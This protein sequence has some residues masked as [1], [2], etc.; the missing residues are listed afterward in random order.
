MCAFIDNQNLYNSINYFK[1]FFNWKAQLLEYEVMNL[2][3][4]CE[5]LNAWQASSRII[6]MLSEKGY[7]E[8]VY[9]YEIRRQLI[10]NKKETINWL[11]KYVSSTSNR[12]LKLYINNS[13]KKG[14]RHKKL[15]DNAAKR[16]KNWKPYKKIESLTV[17]E[18]FV[19]N[20]NK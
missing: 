3:D 4:L 6:N 19:Y 16:I 8:L 9:K 20:N 17:K 13:V 18:Q 11:N 7:Q 15:D 14:I 12:N 1:E 10:D 5:R 2:L